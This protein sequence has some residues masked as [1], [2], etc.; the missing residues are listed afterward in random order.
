MKSTYT[1]R[2]NTLNDPP[3][4]PPPTLHHWQSSP[5]TLMSNPG[6]ATDID[7]QYAILFQK[8]EGGHSTLLLY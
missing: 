1:S 5:P 2:V 4:T 8:G 3:N 7:L 6:S